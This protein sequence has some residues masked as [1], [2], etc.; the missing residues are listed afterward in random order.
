[1]NKNPLTVVATVTVYRLGGSGSM[2]GGLTVKCGQAHAI[3]L[4]RYVWFMHTRA[5]KRVP[6]T[7]IINYRG[8]LTNMG[9]R[10]KVKRGR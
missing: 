8:G 3:E 5:V 4:A 1:M 9:A 2:A 10:G 6:M 7:A